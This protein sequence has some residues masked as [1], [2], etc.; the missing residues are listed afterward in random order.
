M[1]GGLVMKLAAKPAFA[2]AGLQKICAWP[3]AR[4]A[5]SAPGPEM[6]ALSL[7]AVFFANK[8]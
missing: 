3:F 8:L 5:K 2:W 7:D 1:P 4:E 6:F